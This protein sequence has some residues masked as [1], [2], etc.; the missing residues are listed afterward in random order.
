MFFCLRVSNFV[1]NFRFV[2]HYTTMNTDD[3][4]FILT[5][6]VA[7]AAEDELVLKIMWNPHKTIFF[8]IKIDI[9]FLP[10]AI[11]KNSGTF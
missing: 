7:I 10:A 9:M 11:K 1:R 3:H 2:P 4:S 8:A 5:T 6:E